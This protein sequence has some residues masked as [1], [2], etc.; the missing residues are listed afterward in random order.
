MEKLNLT[1]ITQANKKVLIRKEIEEDRLGEEIYS[2]DLLSPYSVYLVRKFEEKIDYEEQGQFEELLTTIL[3]NFEQVFQQFVIKNIYVRTTQ[4]AVYLTFL[5]AL[6]QP[7]TKLEMNDLRIWMNE[8]KVPDLPETLEHLSSTSQEIPLEMVKGLQETT[9]EILLLTEMMNQFSHNLSDI[10][11]ELQVVKNKKTPPVVKVVKSDAVRK[12]AVESENTELIK[13]TSEKVDKLF[14]AFSA[15]KIQVDQRFTALSKPKTPPKFKVF[16]SGEK[17][18][19]PSLESR[20]EAAL[21]EINIL[22]KDVKYSERKITELSAALEKNQSK[23][24][25]KMKLP[26]KKET[27]KKENELEKKLATTTEEVTSLTKQLQEISQ[28]LSTVETNILEVKPDPESVAR[29]EKD[30][31]QLQATTSETMKLNKVIDGLYKKLQNVE[32]ELTTV[33]MTKTTPVIKLKKSETLNNLAKQ[34]QEDQERLTMNAKEIKKLTQTVGKVDVELIKAHQ[35]I[36]ELEQLVQVSKKQVPE[37]KSR[38]PITEPVQRPLESVPSTVKRS[39]SIVGPVAPPISRQMPS[40]ETRQREVTRG[41]LVQEQE[42]LS[43]KSANNSRTLIQTSSFPSKEEFLRALKPLSSQVRLQAEVQ[44]QVQ[45]QARAQVSQKNSIQ[46][47][48]EEHAPV[49]LAIE[50]VLDR[51]SDQPKNQQQ[52]N[53]TSKAA[54]IQAKAELP[55]LRRLKK[56]EWEIHSF[57]EKTRSLGHKGMVSKDDFYG[58]MRKIEVLP[59]LWTKIYEMERRDLMLGTDLSCQQLIDNLDGFIEEV[60]GLSKKRKVMGKWIYCPKEVE[61]KMAGY[62]QLGEYF[63]LYIARKEGAESQQWGY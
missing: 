62:K 8:L 29:I 23:K 54:S 47:V 26:V 37:S 49:T 15:L 19:I 10:Y 25:P 36:A 38:K 3:D 43:Q 53:Y 11:E 48:K 1:K 18:E 30:H 35:K 52:M 31:G 40:M 34:H 13:V 44:A 50:E 5:L 46:P 7:L 9:G 51:V 58:N 57:F 21:K 32:S 59:S 4:K 14:A 28:K 60:E 6:A 41:D 12:Q 55:S 33:K 45:N 63:E 22:T 56:L 27:T 20:L 24:I 61:Q 2:E 17:S 16:F 42:P 39:Q